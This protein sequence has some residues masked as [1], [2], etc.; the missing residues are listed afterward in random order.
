MRLPF[1]CFFLF[2]RLFVF[3]FFFSLPLLCPFLATMS[4]DGFSLSVRSVC[5]PSFFSPKLFPV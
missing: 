3:V 2:V 4:F 5:F 1:V